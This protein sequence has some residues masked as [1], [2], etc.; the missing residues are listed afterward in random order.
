MTLIAACEHRDTPVLI[1]DMALMKG[2]VRSLRKKAYLI[3]PNFVVAWSGHMVVAKLVIS[4][5][6]KAFSGSSVTKTD[7]EAFFTSKEAKDFGT[8]H[9]NFVRWIVEGTD[10]YCFLWNC[11]YPHQVFY[12]AEHFDGSGEAFFRQIRADR[13]ADGGSPLSANDSLIMTALNQVAHLRFHE[14]LYRETWDPTFGVS[15][16]MILW[17]S[18]RFRYVGAVV[19]NGWDYEWDS[20][21]K[22][23]VL[24]QAPVMIRHNCFGNFSVVQEAL[25]GNSFDGKTT[26]YLSRPVFDDMPSADLSYLPFS[27]EEAWL[28]NYFLFRENG[29]TV[30]RTLL[31]V[32]QTMQSGPLKIERRSGA[33]FCSFPS[34]VLDRIHAEYSIDKSR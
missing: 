30:F 11:L 4:E 17:L 1:G 8:L 15:Y 9:T 10:Q 33:Y 21:K 23:G 34:E 6:K 14:S 18:G 5:L 3:S 7:V 26:N 16:A 25:Q 19:Y 28:S 27:L 24:R 13:W 29:E 12:D 31:T 20:S 32:Q 22:T 2:D